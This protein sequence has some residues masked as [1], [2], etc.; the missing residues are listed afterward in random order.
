[1]FFNGG[2]KE[3]CATSLPVADTLESYIKGLKVIVILSQSQ[4]NVR[5]RCAFFLLVLQLARYPRE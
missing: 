3:R 4:N 2:D 1:M 5:N